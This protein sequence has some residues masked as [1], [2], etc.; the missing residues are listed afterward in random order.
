MALGHFWTTTALLAA[1]AQ[2]QDPHAHHRSAPTVVEGGWVKYQHKTAN[3]SLEHP[4]DWRVVSEKTVSIHIAHPTKPVHLFVSAFTMHSA[5]LREFAELKFG[6]EPEMFKP[7]GPAR[8][9]EGVGWSGLVLEAEAG[10]NGERARKRILCA[11]H[12]D[13]Y[14]S[15]ALHIDA[16]ELAAPGEDY[17]RLFRSLRFDAGATAPS[18]PPAQSH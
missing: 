4:P 6:A 14:V 17:E 12:E 5:T 2:G 16:G 8:T 18:S 11:K 7:L 10:A 9:M 1:L 15:L 13:L 3:F